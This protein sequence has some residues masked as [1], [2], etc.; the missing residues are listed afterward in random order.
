[1]SY[2]GYE[3]IYCICGYR[4]ATLDAHE[5]FYRDNEPHQPC[6]ICGA[7]E[8]AWDCVNLTNGCECDYYIKEWEAGGK[9][10]PTPLCSAHERVTKVVEIVGEQICPCC[11]GTGKTPIN[12]Y[13]ISM[14]RKRG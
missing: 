11:K 6:P 10:G 4:K 9:I 12:R 1:M 8:E 2:E 3:V 14:L 7:T 13:D 5:A